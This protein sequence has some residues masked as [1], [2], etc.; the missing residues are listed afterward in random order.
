M[1]NLRVAIPV[2]TIKR[3]IEVDYVMVDDLLGKEFNELVQQAPTEDFYELIT[4]H[5]N[6]YLQ[7]RKM[8]PTEIA[9]VILNL[10]DDHAAG[11]KLTIR[12]GDYISLQ[13]YLRNKK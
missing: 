3:R 13:N 7:E 5:M 9:T 4:R 11:R 10:V 2:W 8:P 1:E 6:A 12:A